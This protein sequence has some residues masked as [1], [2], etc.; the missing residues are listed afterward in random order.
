M[1]K[2]TKMQGTGNDGIYVDCTKQNQQN[3]K[4]IAQQLCNRHLGIGADGLIL[5]LESKIADFKMEIYN[6]DG[7]QAEMCG[8]G[9]RCAG[10]F[11]Y[12]KGLTNK[13]NIKIE[14]LAGIK[15]LEL[16][17]KNGIVETVRVDMGEPILEAKK[18]PAK[19]DEK[20]KINLQIDNRQ[21]EITCVSM[22]NPHGVTFV[23]NVE[24]TD[25]EKYGSKL[26]NN[27][28]FPQKANIEFVEKIDD[29]N[30]KMRVWERGVGET[31]ACGTGA[32]ASVVASI[33]NKKTSN[34]V[35]VHLKGGTLLIEW[36]KNNHVYM[37]GPAETSFEGEFNEEKYF[38]KEI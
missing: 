18:I 16:N 30:I 26:E 33:L 8:N 1:I 6:S 9:I 7:S 11:V 13:T 10:K 14:T 35:N 29:N 19:C 24:Q 12:E 36:N 32:C 4:K 2:F 22:G 34:K 3:I 38:Y 15:D 20:G 27:P 5:I 37:T 28:A 25:V 31:M 21:F 23:Q 17:V